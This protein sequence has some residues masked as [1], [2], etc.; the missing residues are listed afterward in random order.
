MVYILLADGFE[1]VEAVSPADALRRA[2]VETAFVGVTGMTVTA[3]HGLRVTADAALAD[4]DASGC[5]AII[6]PGGL[7][8]V[9]NIK[10]SGAA[11]AAVKAAFDAG[12]LV[13]AI[14]AGPTV[15]AEL[16]ILKGKKAVCYPGMEAELTGARVRPGESVVV[17]GNVITSR[18]AGTA[19]DFAFALLAALRGVDAAKKVAGD[20]H[21][22]HL[23][24]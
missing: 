23:K 5:E 19:W 21:Y 2:R 8:G 9:Q 13:G 15:L 1:E 10:S 24:V 14:C 12:R 22:D 16:G 18:S 7:R 3:S 6:V 17:D 4:I 11:M 20:V